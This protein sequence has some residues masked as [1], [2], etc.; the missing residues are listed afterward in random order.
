MITTLKAPASGMMGR[1]RS[2]KAR[3]PVM[4][5][6]YCTGEP[7]HGSRLCIRGRG[8]R[9]LG[10]L[11]SLTPQSSTTRLGQ[12]RR[13]NNGELDITN[14][15][16]SGNHGSPGAVCIRNIGTLTIANG[17]SRQHSGIGAGVIIQR[18]IRSI[19]SSAIVGNE[20]GYNR[21]CGLHGGYFCGGPKEG[22]GIA[23]DGDASWSTVHFGQSG[24]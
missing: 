3:L 6:H 12:V 17:L 22:G 2:S 5:P 11:P 16:I 7:L 4:L 20:T 13:N 14:S 8:V 9:Q 10:Y 21:F 15:M 24:G 19:I 1:C 23:N 18:L